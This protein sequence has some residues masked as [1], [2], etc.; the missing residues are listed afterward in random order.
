[1]PFRFTVSFWG[2]AEKELSFRKSKITFSFGRKSQGSFK[3]E[4]SRNVFG[5]SLCFPGAISTEGYSRILECNCTGSCPFLLCPKS[6]QVLAIL[7]GASLKRGAVKNGTKQLLLYYLCCS[8]PWKEKCPRNFI[9]LP[10]SQA[11]FFW[12]FAALATTQSIL[13]YVCKELVP[14]YV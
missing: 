9:R 6:L 10:Y 4:V 14:F 5:K 12:H 1:M 11:C 3:N 7:L 13:Q 8:I 2:G